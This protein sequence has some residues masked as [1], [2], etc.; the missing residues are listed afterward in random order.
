MKKGSR[1]DLTLAYL[2]PPLLTC[3]FYGAALLLLPVVLHTREPFWGLLFVQAPLCF[4]GY[5]A[6]SSRRFR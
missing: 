3:L 4:L 5:M 1:L 2:I 6:W